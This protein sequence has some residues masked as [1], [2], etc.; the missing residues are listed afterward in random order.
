V[1]KEKSEQYK[2]MELAS[3]VQNHCRQSSDNA[4]KSEN[5]A[6]L[7]CSSREHRLFSESEKESK[8]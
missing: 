7:M 6:R 2:T 1:N 5:F 3:L 4:K 8:D